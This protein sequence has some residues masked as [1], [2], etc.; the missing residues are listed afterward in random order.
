MPDAHAPSAALPYKIAVLC[1]LRDAQGRVLLLRRTKHPN[2]GLCSPIGGKLEMHT[3]ESPAQCARR[4]IMEEAGIDV[5]IER[6]RL[7]GMISE[8]AFEGA[9]HWLIFWYRVVGPV[10]VESRE[11][12]EGSLEWHDPAAI[13][14]LPLPNT[15][16][17]VIW[18]LVNEH[19]GGFFAVHIDCGPGKD[20][21]SW[22]I[23]QAVKPAATGN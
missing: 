1:D 21:L 20:D 19:D 13:D 4:E 23:E 18:P 11:I 9:G 22:V 12:R 17:R 8:T 16:R 10:E 2:F 7:A 5:P 6:L 3:G 15:D 14:A